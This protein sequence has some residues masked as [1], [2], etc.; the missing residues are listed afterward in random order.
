MSAVQGRTISGGTIGSRVALLRLDGRFLGISPVQ[1]AR[2]DGRAFDAERDTG[3]ALLPT[4]D[5]FERNTSRNAVRKD[6]YLRGFA[7]RFI[8]LCSASLT[9]AVVRQAVATKGELQVAD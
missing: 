3:L 2:R 7:Y 1:L 6:R 5:L 4:N 8:E 9:E